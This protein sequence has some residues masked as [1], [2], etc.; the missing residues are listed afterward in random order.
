MSFDNFADGPFAQPAAAPQQ[1]AHNPF[2]APA[3]SAAPNPFDAGV[4]SAPNGAFGGHSPSNGGFGGDTFNFEPVQQQLNAAAAPQATADFGF[5]APG[6]PPTS[7]TAGFA[8][9]AALPATNDFG[10][11]APAPTAPSPTL[12]F[13]APAAQQPSNDFG[14]GAPAA[15]PPSPTLGFSAPAAAPSP[16]PQP[17]PQPVLDDF[18]F[19]APAG[20]TAAD[21]FG[22]GAPAAQSP[23]PTLGFS[24]PLAAPSPAQQLPADDFGFGAPAAQPAAD[25]FGFGAPAPQP[26]AQPTPQPAVQAAAP[27]TPKADDFGFAESN[28][29]SDPFSPASANT[30]DSNHPFATGA[31]APAFDPFLATQKAYTEKVD[32]LQR[33]GSEMFPDFRSGGML[34]EFG[35]SHGF[36][37]PVSPLSRRAA[38]VTEEPA[39]PPVAAA[40]RTTS[41]MDEDEFSPNGG[42]GDFFDSTFQ[43]EIQQTSDRH[44][45]GEEYEV[46]FDF[47]QKLGMLLERQDV[48]T[49][50]SSEK[51]QATV[52]KILVPGGPADQKG[53]VPQSVLVAINGN[54]VHGFDYHK[55]DSVLR[56]GFVCAGN[57]AGE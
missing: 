28:G 13:S 54:N 48:Y 7:T 25:D 36:E 16:K 6:T 5:G 10:F 4:N 52:A 2:D 35:S 32:D 15:H 22:F 33:Q 50:G 11:G 39:T 17:Q 57:I 56:P 1:P 43:A 30:F 47:E 49:E 26:A 51:T 19:G 8:A 21:D 29:Q 24:A 31:G 3:P 20:Q 42:A 27:P 40:G 53:V 14:F 23:S 9:P 41:D 55:V 37:S 46:T 12:G 38:T 34:P 18:G 45:V 44:A